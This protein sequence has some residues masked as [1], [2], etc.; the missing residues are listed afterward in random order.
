MFCKG[1]HL[2]EASKLAKPMKTL[3]QHKTLGA[4]S[5]TLLSQ[6]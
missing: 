6:Q 2:D 5:L 3:K 1:R 4:L